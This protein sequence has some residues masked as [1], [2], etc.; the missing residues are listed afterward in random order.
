MV[1]GG[2]FDWASYLARFHT[3][4]PGLI[5]EVVG[6]SRSGDH[7]PYQWL[8]RAVSQRSKRVLDIGCGGGE[9]SE[10][11]ALPGR[12]VFGLDV[13]VAELEIASRRPGN[14][15]CADARQMPFADS[16]M[17]A[18]VSSLAMLVIEPLDQVISEVARV[19]RPGGVFAF[20]CPTIRPVSGADI[21][22]GLQ[23]ARRLRA[24]PRFP[25]GLELAFSP[26]LAHHGLRKVE[27]ARER[28]QFAVRSTADAELMLRATYLP[29]VDEPHLLQTAAWLAHEAAEKD[30]VL[31]PL[32]MRRF[33]AIK[34]GK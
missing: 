5:G 28:Y 25:G 9:L 31:V 33:V 26:L 3:Q 17:D 10:Q 16:S 7:S 24:I 12:E 1:L 29:A 8:A 6:R 11:L 20:L 30:E 4:R 2:S 34:T 19:L 18:V 13:S 21:R 15:V 23:I 14:W 32:P 27:D 22:V